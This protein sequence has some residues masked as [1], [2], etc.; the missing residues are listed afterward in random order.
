MN[1]AL[2]NSIAGTSA[3]GLRTRFSFDVS[4]LSRE[5]DKISLTAVSE[6]GALPPSPLRFFEKNR[7]K[8]SIFFL[9]KHTVKKRAEKNPRPF[10][11]LFAA[12]FRRTFNL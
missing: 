7:V 10:S 11:I 2:Q 9:Y 12:G 6:N 8:L 1:F 4:R 5:K 3:A